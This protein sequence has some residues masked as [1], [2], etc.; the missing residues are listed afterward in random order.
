V[1]LLTRQDFIAENQGFDLIVNLRSEV[2]GALG[3]GLGFC[4]RVS[5]GRSICMKKFM[6]SFFTNVSNPFVLV[7]E[8]P[9][10]LKKDLKMIIPNANLDRR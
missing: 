6:Q 1:E 8:T 3:F 5:H 9:A 2:L 10:S 7:N 4:R